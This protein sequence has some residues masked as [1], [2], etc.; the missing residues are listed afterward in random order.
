ML[1]SIGSVLYLLE[2]L[3]PFP[4]PVP[5]GKWGFSNMVLLLALSG[6]SFQDLLILAA[7]KSFIGGLLTGRIGTPGFI[8]GFSGV[9]V[10]ACLMWLLSKTRLFGFAGISLAGAAM[11]NFVQLFIAAYLIIKS[12]EI[13]FLYPY[14]LLLGTISALI[15]AY[16]AYE[17]IRRIGGSL[18]FD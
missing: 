14:M 11:S 15:N 13:L 5:G 2:S 18:W 9:L 17:V 8:M 6:L 7:G 1:I 10:S 3:I 12:R 4:L 16:I